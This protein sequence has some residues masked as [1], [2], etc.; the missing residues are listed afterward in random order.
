MNKND[1]HIALLMMVKNEHKRLHVSLNSVLGYVDSIVMYDTGSEDN[2]IEIASNFCKKNNITFRLKEGTFVDFSTS[3]NV[4]LDFAD[5]FED[6]DYLLLLDSNDELQGGSQLRKFC[7]EQINSP[8]TGFL[9][10]Q[11]WWNGHC[12]KYY[13]LRMVKARQGW[14][15]VGTVHEWMKNTRFKTEEEENSSEDKKIRIP[16]VVLYQ[17][18]TADDDKSSKRFIRDKILLLKEHEDN[19]SD[20]RTIFYLAQT[21]ACLGHLEEAF[22]FYSLRSTLE[23]FWEEKFQSFFKCG[24]VL[25]LMGNEW[26]DSMKWY[27]KAFD[28]TPRVEPLIKIVEYYRNKNWDLSYTFCMLACKLNYPDHCILFVDKRMYDYKRWHLLGIVGWYSGNYNDGKLGCKKAIEF[29]NA[30][31]DINN[32]KF[33]EEKEINDKKILKDKLKDKLKSKKR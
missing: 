5:T 16:E 12:I 9:V 3:R 15:Y 28:Y 21:C 13:N 29:A 33:Y 30:E 31:I 17:D 25:E 19:P 2:T 8:N 11:E 7:N 24:E 20:T 23:G 1:V 18:R 10:C 22:K 6:I 27:L 14:R 4:S 26:Y 32:L